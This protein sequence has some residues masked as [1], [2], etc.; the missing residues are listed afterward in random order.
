MLTTEDRAATWLRVFNEQMAK[1]VEFTGVLPEDWRSGGRRTKAQ[2]EGE[3]IS[4][5]RDEIGLGQIEAYLS[6]LRQSRWAIA[7][8]PDG[9]A[10]IE[11]DGVVD[12]G[13]KPVRFIIDAVYQVGDDLVLVDYKTGARTPPGSTQLG[14]YASALERLHGIRPKWGAF[15]KTRNAELSELVDL[16]T[17][18]MDYFDYQFG[19]MN[20]SID[21]GYFPPSVGEH[22]NWC[23][24]S[25]FCVAVR[26]PHSSAWP[27]ATP[28][29]KTDE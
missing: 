13:G 27:L 25:D 15:Y 14:L 21:T 8:L 11:W 18:G 22:C 2:P 4:V 17:W 19:A 1:D 12:F 20:A 5:W 23:S 10:G 28:K 6:W 7:T 29:E 3:T 26:G 16:S 9:R 24:V